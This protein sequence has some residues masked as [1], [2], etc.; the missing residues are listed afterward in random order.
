MKSQAILGLSIF[1]I[2]TKIDDNTLLL[3]LTCLWKNLIVPIVQNL[4]NLVSF[5]DE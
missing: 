3:I 2:Y 1:L 5:R 4:Q